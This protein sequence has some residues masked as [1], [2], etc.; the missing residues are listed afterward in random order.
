[1]RLTPRAWY[2]IGMIGLTLFFLFCVWAYN[3]GSGRHF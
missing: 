1:M 3:D 2:I